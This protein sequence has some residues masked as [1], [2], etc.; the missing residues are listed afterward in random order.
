MAPSLSRAKINS[1]LRSIYYN[2][3]NANAFTGINNLY[4]AARQKLKTLK[5]DQVKEWAK[6]QDTY[7]IHRD[8][9]AKFK[10]NRVV[11]HFID[12][13]WDADLVDLQEF[14]KY[15]GG[16][17]YLLT[18]I[19][20]LSKYAWA[21]PIKLKD[22][23]SVTA[24]FEGIFE[25][26]ARVPTKIR[27]DRGKEFINATFQKMC[28]TNK[29]NHFVTE[30]HL[31][32]CVAERFNRTLKTK[33]WKYF[34][35]NH[36]FNYISVLKDLVS[37]Y[38]K[39]KHSS[40]KMAP[41]DVNLT[42]QA[43]VYKTLFPLHVHAFRKYDGDLSIGDYVRLVLDKSVFHKGYTG[44]FSEEIY[45]VRAIKVTGD[46]PL[47]YIADLEGEEIKGS[48]YREEIQPVNIKKN[49]KFVIEK[50]LQTKTERGK[51]QYFVKWFGYPDKFNSWVDNVFSA[52]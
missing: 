11:V 43:Q 33:M 10:R 25:E 8:S 47:F 15:N 3:K 36:T 45:R 35:S 41:C 16:H 22:A 27:T 18:V 6:S 4:D 29:I 44:N 49:K 52:K 1:T 39:K 9:V 38:N 42:N 7:T 17:K 14:A 34:S 5:L 28:S 24:A 32:A 48:H 26:S 37:G 51:K 30:N 50:V 23:Q 19:D 20:I 12:E 46:I 21:I 13:Q 31:K 2:P 40:I